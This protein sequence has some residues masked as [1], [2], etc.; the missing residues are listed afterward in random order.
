MGYKERTVGGGPAK[1]LAKDFTSFL[2]NFIN[3]GSFGG[4]TAGQQAGAANP[5]GDAA[6]IFSLLN[7]II[8]NPQADQSVQTLIN[9]DIERGTNALRA[10]YGASGGMPF[11]TGAQVAEGIYQSEQAPR[12]ALA[13]DQLAQSR[14]G[15]LM[16]FFQFARDIAGLG[17]PQAQATLEPDAWMQGFNALMDVANTAA[18][19]IPGGGGGETGRASR[20]YNQLGGARSPA[21]I[22]GGPQQTITPNFPRIRYPTPTY[23]PA[24]P[25]E[26][27]GANRNFTPIPM[28]QYFT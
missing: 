8:S 9:K 18:N 17:I 22:G 28:Q 16:P 21:G 10:R 15:A 19:F 1:G 2:Q 24:V 11:G 7:S 23:G 5:M 25:Y 26:I 27:Y 14:L 6:G 20:A 12:T 4:G 3:S 13:M